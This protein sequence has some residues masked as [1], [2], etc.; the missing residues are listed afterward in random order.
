M[1]ILIAVSSTGGRKACARRRSGSRRC[2]CP[3]DCLRTCGAGTGSA[4]PSTRWS[5][6]TAS[7][8]RSVR[9]AFATAVKR[10]GIEDHVT[11]H[12]LRHTAA[13]WAMQSGGDLWQT[14]GYLGMTVEMLERVYG[15]HHPDFQRE[16]AEGIARSPG[17]IR[18][19]NQ[20]PF[21]APT[22][23]LG[24]AGQK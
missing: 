7:R 8:W 3:I 21:I 4:S 11:P 6:G 22:A 10:A 16:A 18:D 19:K 13:T 14:A 12:I 1:S 15:H 9:K 5:N 17:Q 23:D 2:G 24:V 20:R